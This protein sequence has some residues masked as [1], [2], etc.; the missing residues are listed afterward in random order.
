MLA[1][2]TPH[3]AVVVVAVGIRPFVMVRKA[4]VDTRAYPFPPD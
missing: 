3:I 2:T 1:L 4:M